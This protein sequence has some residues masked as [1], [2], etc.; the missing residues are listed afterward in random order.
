MAHRG[1][2]CSQ[3]RD[4]CVCNGASIGDSHAYTYTGG[5]SNRYSYGYSHIYAH[6][7]AKADAHAEI[8]A[9]EFVPLRRPGRRRFLWPG[10][11]IAA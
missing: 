2:W 1:H 3:W 11:V 8:R 10:S 4:S 9:R 6:F 5:Y 7:D